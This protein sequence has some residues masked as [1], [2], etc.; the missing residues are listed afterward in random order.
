MTAGIERGVCIYTYILRAAGRQ[1]RGIDTQNSLGHKRRKEGKG[2]NGG[3]GKNGTRSL[4][5]KRGEGKMG[6][7]R[8]YICIYHLSLR[9]EALFVVNWLIISRE[10]CICL[11]G[12][13][14]KNHP[15]VKIGKTGKTY[16]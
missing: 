1:R 13:P 7:Q 4:W 11:N 8:T 5:G 6:H 10:T 9:R 3:K 14:N 12:N 15:E 16:A 2:G